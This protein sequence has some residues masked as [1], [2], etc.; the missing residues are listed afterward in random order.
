MK[1]YDRDLRKVKIDKFLN[2]SMW[3]RGIKH[4]THKIKVKAVKEGEVVRVYAI[5]LP[6]NIDFKKKREERIAKEA[7]EKVKKK[8]AEIKAKEEA[9]KKA[10][11]EKKEEEKKE[12][13]EEKKAAVVEAGKEMEKAAAKQQKHA[14]KAGGLQP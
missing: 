4:P 12:G 7:E 6:K 10:V 8:A 11:E 3:I 2:E 9:A 1:V 13:S 5:D 14:T